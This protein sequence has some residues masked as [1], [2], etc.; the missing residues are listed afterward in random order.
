MGKEDEEIT[1]FPL[2]GWRA[3]TLPDQCGMLEIQYITNSFQR[4]EDSQSLSFSM[5]AA[6][7]SKLAESLRRMSEEALDR[8]DCLD[9]QVH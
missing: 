3:A 2:T 7:A 9:D 8:H 6:L 5:T 1:L 4:V